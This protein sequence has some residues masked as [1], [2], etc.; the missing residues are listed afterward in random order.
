MALPALQ[1]VKYNVLMS[2]IRPR[3]PEKPGIF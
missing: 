2:T 3:T 1:W